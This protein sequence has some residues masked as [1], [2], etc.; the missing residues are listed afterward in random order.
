MNPLR[1]NLFIMKISSRN[2][3]PRVSQIMNPAT[4]NVVTDKVIMVIHTWVGKL[5]TLKINK[6]LMTI[7]NDHKYQG[8]VH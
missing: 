5:V 3:F 1:A 6:H 7:V 2:I 8:N 4:N